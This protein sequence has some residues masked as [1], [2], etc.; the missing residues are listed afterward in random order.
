MDKPSG[1]GEL[2]VVISLGSMDLRIVRMPFCI[3]LHV[4]SVIRF[5]SCRNCREAVLWDGLHTP[6]MLL[7]HH[8][9]GFVIFACSDF[10]LKPW[11]EQNGCSIRF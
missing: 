2:E 6:Y 7:M 8:L 9:L 10:W 1:V 4:M 5:V 3:I 11:V